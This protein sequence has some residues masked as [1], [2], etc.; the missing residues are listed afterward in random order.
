MKLITNYD[1]EL[2]ISRATLFVE[3]NLFA[4][5]TF[6]REEDADV[7]S[8]FAGCQFAEI[9]AKIKYLK[10]LYKRENLKLQ[11]IKNLYH[12]ITQLKEFEYDE[13]TRTC[14]HIRKQIHIKTQE[15]NN[16]KDYYEYL[17]KEYPNIVDKRL[18][19]A[20]EINKSI[21]KQLAEAKED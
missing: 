10:H 6:L 1:E 18:D 2:G 8:S 17:Q 9:K 13:H 16:I 5:M 7:A 14:R 12:Q 11:A 3:N 4:G 15:V 19:K 21:A 20:R